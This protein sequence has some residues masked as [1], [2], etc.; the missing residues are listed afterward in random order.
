MTSA[1]A[2][3]PCTSTWAFH[4]FL[5]KGAWVS[6]KERLEKHWPPHYY[7]WVTCFQTSFSWTLSSILYYWSFSP[8]WTT[9]PLYLPRGGTMVREAGGRFSS[10]LSEHAFWPPL[11]AHPF[12]T[13]HSVLE[14]LTALFWAFS[15]THSILTLPRQSHQHSQLQ[16]SPSHPNLYL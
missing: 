8:F 15:S 4:T 7:I 13:S 6:I 10:C 12:L 3:F 9:L 11:Q 2:L 16:L 1:L 5:V 14:F